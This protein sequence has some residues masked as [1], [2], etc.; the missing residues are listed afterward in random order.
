[1]F[2][3]PNGS[4]AKV[5]NHS[6]G[7]MRAWVEIGFAYECDHNHAIDVATRACDELAKTLDYVVE[8]PKVMGIQKLDD[9]SVVLAIWAK[10]TNMKQWALERDIRKAVKEAFDRE[11]VEIPFPR[12]VVIH[13]HEGEAQKE[14]NDDREVRRVPAQDP[15]ESW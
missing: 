11:G 5:T 10:A 4:I 8:G 14:A 12:R 15:G 2:F 13:R 3:I 7:D 1:V 6:R 9:S